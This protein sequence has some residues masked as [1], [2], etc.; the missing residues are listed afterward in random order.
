MKKLLI[1]C[2]TCIVTGTFAQKKEVDSIAI[3]LAAYKTV[4]L[5]TDISKMSMEEREGLKHLIKAAEMVDQIFW[6]QAYGGN[7]AADTVSK[8]SVREFMRINYGPWDRLDNNR[9][10]IEGVG[11]KPLGANF[12]PSDMRKGEFDSL[13]DESK[14]SPYTIIVREE[15][16]LKVKKY[17]DA[18]QHMIREAS[19][20]LNHA[21][22]FFRD[23]MFS[24]YLTKR[25]EAL[26]SNNYDESDRI[27]LDMK[28]NR[29][30]IIIGPIESYEDRLYGI[31][32]SY[33]AYVLVKDMEW[34]KR[35]EKYVAYLG[36]LQ[37]GLP[38]DARYKKE[39]AGMSSQLA[40]YDIV[41]YAGDCNSGS[42]TIAVNL[43]NDPV[44]QVQ[45]GTRRSQLKNTIKA[46]FDHILIPIANELVVPEQRKHITFNAFFSDI[47]FH[48]VAHGLGIKETINGKGTVQSALGPHYS[49]L[50]EGKAD[51]LGLYMITQLYEKKVLTEGEL[52]DYYVSFM[53][54]IF[55]SVRFGVG[56]AHGQANI[57]RFNYFKEAGAFSRDAKTGQYKLDMA[58]MRQAMTSLSSLILKLQGDGDIEG[59]QKLINEKGSIG[60]E[61]RK[62]LDRLTSKNIPVDIVFEQ[63][64]EVL[65][66]NRPPIPEE[67]QK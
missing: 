46:K 10:F 65:D 17:P 39:Q 25:A 13:T 40:A 1:A 12:Y 26:L 18:Y 48:E 22:K 35:L 36:E 29:F 34:S 11:A 61:L 64:I 37:E 60:P 5:T 63:G 31:K 27:W 58:K 54:G 42:K 55:R 49:A 6:M 9:P 38:V 20:E 28:D 43:P 67:M 41:Y 3:K 16:V 59:V 23:S 50:E 4:R 24:L 44:L 66:L 7:L 57:I 21:A 56:S 53:A 19:M 14:N 47:M 8:K 51:I 33:E 45:K 62:D 15:G 30:D 32:T 2:L 52:M